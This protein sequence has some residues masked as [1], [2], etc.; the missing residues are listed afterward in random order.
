MQNEIIKKKL[1]LKEI[2]LLSITIVIGVYMLFVSNNN[3]QHPILGNFT[4]G[5][6]FVIKKLESKVDI[7]GVVTVEV[8]PVPFLPEDLEWKFNIGLN[9][10]SIELDQDMTK[11]SVLF[12]ENGRE[13]K[14]IRWEGAVSGG[15]H[16][17]GI[18]VFKSIVP[19][20][21]SIE[22]KIVDIDAPVRS[23]VWNI[24]N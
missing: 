17:E 20:P 12:D 19:I 9:T 11:V 16:R 2:L 24:I 14:P 23:F 10:H 21:K 15:H 5:Q 18:L 1:K 3:M 8:T 13:Y 22:L 6:N 7:Q 4:Q